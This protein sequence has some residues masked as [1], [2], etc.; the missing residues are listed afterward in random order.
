M[1]TSEVGKLLGDQPPHPA[2]HGRFVVTR[3]AGKLPDHLD[4]H[5][6]H[7]V[8]QLDLFSQF[9]PQRRPHDDAEVSAVVLAK[10]SQRL[11]LPRSGPGQKR[12]R[13]VVHSAVPALSKTADHGDTP[14]F[15]RAGHPAQVRGL[16]AGRLE[17]GP[18][19]LRRPP[20]PSE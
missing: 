5:F 10:L 14:R 9:G 6:L 20:A 11:G 8:G 2:Q 4:E 18:P 12:E 17:P 3:E 1:K 15:D 16:V 13:R 19:A 7:H